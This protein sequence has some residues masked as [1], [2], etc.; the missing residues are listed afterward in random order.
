[1]TSTKPT[2]YRM[3]HH[4]CVCVCVCVCAGGGIT[5]MALRILHLAK[6]LSQVH[7][8]D[9]IRVEKKVSRF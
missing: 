8:R 3:Y 9:E 4:L 1:M 6:K 5:Y 7:F 2:S